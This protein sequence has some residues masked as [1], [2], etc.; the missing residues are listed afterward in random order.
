MFAVGRGL[1]PRRRPPLDGRLARIRT[2]VR[3]EAVGKRRTLMDIFA[4]WSS[5]ATTFGWQSSTPANRRREVTV[6]TRRAGTPGAPALVCV[7]GFPTSSIDYF[8]LVGELGAEIDIFLLDFP[9]Y[10]ARVKRVGHWE[11]A[12]LIPSPALPPTDSPRPQRPARTKTRPSTPAQPRSPRSQGDSR[13]TPSGT[14]ATTQRARPENVPLR[15]SLLSSRS[16][17]VTDCHN[18]RQ[19]LR[20]LAQPVRQ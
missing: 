4:Q 10:G 8:A 11:P 7:H 15:T 3:I 9:G 14:T 13:S 12:G 5:G 16:G 1:S 20:R 2:I 18:L 17:I 6:F 19:T